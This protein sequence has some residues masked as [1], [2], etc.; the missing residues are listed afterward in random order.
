MQGIS[1][2]SV[3]LVRMPA[4]ILSICTVS[5]TMRQMAGHRT[6]TICAIADVLGESCSSATARSSFIGVFAGLYLVVLIVTIWKPLLA[7][8][9]YGLFEVV[10]AA[11]ILDTKQAFPSLSRCF[12]S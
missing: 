4:P 7:T 6:P 2:S 9:G 8:G 10:F 1:R 12:T 11:Y 5:I 3:P